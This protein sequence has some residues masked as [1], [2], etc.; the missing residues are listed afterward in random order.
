MKKKMVVLIF[1]VALASAGF[2]QALARGW[3]DGRGAGGYY[4]TDCPGGC[5]GQYQQL[6]EEAQNKLK[7][8][9]AETA[10]LRKQMAMKRAEKQALMRA[11]TPDP[12]AVAK[13]EGEL[14]DLRNE[15][16]QKAQEAGV[17]MMGRSGG[18]G[19]HGKKMMPCGNQARWN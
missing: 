8:F 1:T 16:Q 10:D 13:V 17:P 11:Q 7:V 12:A 19:Y 6:D 4:G 3:G 5:Y 15:M 9:R 2:Q 18:K 14:F